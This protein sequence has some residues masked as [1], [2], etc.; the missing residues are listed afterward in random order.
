MQR[1]GK[2]RSQGA[3]LPDLS[4]GQGLSGDGRRGGMT[5]SRF[6]D[7]LFNQA[8]FPS[9]IKEFVHPGKDPSELLMRCVFKDERQ[10]NA[11]VLWLAK[12]NEFKLERHKQLLLH[13]LAASTSIKGMARKE[14]LQAVTGII[15][16]SLFGRGDGKKGKNEE[17]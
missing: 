3:G 10:A 1:R 6:L 9:A 7:G 14:L 8:Q 15:A 12:C 16:P 11:A 2:N 17:E 5:D 13:K 4:P